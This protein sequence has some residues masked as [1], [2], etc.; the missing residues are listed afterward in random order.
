MT[1]I[2]AKSRFSTKGTAFWR[3]F[4]AVESA[5]ADAFGKIFEAA[6]HRSKD[7]LSDKLNKA[8][9]VSLLH[10]DFL[11]EIGDILSTEREIGY[12]EALDMVEYW[13][14]RQ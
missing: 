8:R 10:L 3:E 1:V 13:L 7:T 4:S 2:D 5:K 14:K 12:L 9:D 11:S 6:A